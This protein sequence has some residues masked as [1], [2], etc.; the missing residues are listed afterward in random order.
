MRHHHLKPHQPM[1][2]NRKKNRLMPHRF[3]R[4]LPGQSGPNLQV[5]MVKASNLPRDSLQGSSMV[6]ES[7]FVISVCSTNA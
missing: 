3:G 1:I 5:R 2:D 7:S 4:P 6:L